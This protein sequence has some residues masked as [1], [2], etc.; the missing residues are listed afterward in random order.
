MPTLDLAGRQ[1]G[2]LTAVEYAGKSRWRCECSCGSGKTVVAFTNNLTRG[3]TKSCGCYKRERSLEANRTHGLRSAPEYPI[4]NTMISRCYRPSI[5]RYPY[6]GGRGITV[7]A[8]W[9]ESFA[10]F[11]ADMGRRPSSSHQIDRIDNDGNYEP[12]NCRWATRQQQA[13]NKSNNTHLTVDGRTQTLAAWERETG[14]AA[15]MICRRIS[16][17]WSAVDAVTIGPRAVRK[18]GKRPMQDVGVH[19]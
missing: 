16:R 14:L 8:Q 4:W 7:C 9:R 2:R 6:Y 10:A 17:G 3:T 12:S 19:A 18:W 15:S 11:I 13:N 1:F 5:E